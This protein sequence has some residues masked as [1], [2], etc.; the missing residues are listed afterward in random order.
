MEQPIRVMIVDDHKIVREGLRTLLSEERTIEVV[1]EATSGEEALQLAPDVLPTVV[2]MD[3]VLP[4][5]DGLETTRRLKSTQPEC[6]VLVLT[7]FTD[8]RQVHAALQ[9]GATGYLMK[10]LLKPDLLSAIERAARDEPTLHP[11]AQRALIRQA[12]APPSPLESLTQREGDVL[13]LIAGGRSNREI[14]AEL[15]LSEGTVKG[16]VSTI[17]SKLEVADRTQAALLAVRHGV[18]GAEE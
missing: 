5:I 6:R 2:L 8:D 13:R 11:A 7:S 17:L 4:G 15:H 12:T 10:D 14:A 18:G 1:A 9:A 16:Y 3:L